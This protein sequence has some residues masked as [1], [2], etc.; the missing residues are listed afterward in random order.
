MKSTYLFLIIALFSLFPSAQAN[1]SAYYYFKQI[2]I[3]EGLPSSVTTVYDGNDG[4]L[5]IGTIYGAYR[6][7]G[8]KLKRY[9]PSAKGQNIPYIYR[10]DGDKQGNIWMFHPEGT[11]RYNPEKDIFEAFLFNNKPLEAH[12]LLSESNQLIFP[13]IGALLRYTKDL[14]YNGRIIVKEGEK[15]VLCRKIKIYNEKYYIASTQY[16]QLVLIDRHTG[17]VQES[18]FG[19]QTN[20]QDFYVDSKQ[21]FWI[22]YYGKGVSCYTQGGSLI[23]SFHTR[24]SSLSN[25][26]VLDIEERNGDIWLATDGGGINIIKGDTEEITVLSNNHDHKFPANSVTCLHNGVNNMWIGM[27][28]E[29]VLGAKENFITTYS[30]APQNDPSGLSEKC[31]LSLLEDKDGTIWIGT[32]GGGINSFNPK[33]EQFTHFPSTSG[34]KIVSI[35]PYSDSELL[36]SSFT[37]GIYLFDKKSGRYHRFQ[38]MGKVMDDEI[39]YS[40]SPTN[41][42]VNFENEIEFHGEYAYR[43]VRDKNLFTK[44]QV[45][46]RQYNESAIAIGNY[47]ADTY[48]H[49]KN[50]VFCYNRQSDRFES[51]YK[52]QGNQIL[53]AY[54]EPTGGRIWI[55]EKSGLSIYHIESGKTTP[56]KLPDQNDIVTSLIMDRKGVLWMGTSGALYAYFPKEQRFILFSESDGVLPNDFLPKPV[57]LTRNGDVYMG[58]AMGLARVNQS[59]NKQMHETS[60]A[61][62]ISLLDVNLNGNN[63]VPEQ[64]GQVSRLEIPSNFSSLRVHTKLDGTDIFRKR[65]YRY[66]I[67]GLNH[68]FTESS[69]SHF[70]IPTLPPGHYQIKAQCTQS[71]GLWS[72]PFTLLDLTVLPPWWQRTWFILCVVAALISAIIYIIRRREEHLQQKLKEKEREIYKEKVQALI[73]INHELRTPLTLIYTPL[74]Q[75]LSSRQVPLELRGKLQGAFKQARQMKNIINMILHM[76]KMEVGKN[77]L[78]LTPTLLN[79]WLQDIVNDFK[80]EFDMRNIRLVFDADSNI[81]TV[82]FDVGQCEIILNNLLMNAYKFSHPD[83]TVTVSTRLEQAGSII[84]IEVCDEGI[85]LGAVDPQGL[86]TRFEQGDH[87][88]QG[89]GIGLSYAKQLVEMHQGTIGAMNNKEKGATFYFTLPNRQEPVCVPCPAKPYL[90]EL[91]PP[92]TLSLQKAE[93]LPNRFHS[94][95]I[96][97]DDPDLCDYL[98]CNL[99][100]MFEVI[101]IAHDGM[102]AIPIVVSHLP[103]LIISDVIMPRMD[104]LELCRK[105]KQSAEF[106]YIPVILLASHADE[107]STE[108]GYKTGADAYVAK[109]FDMDTL[110]LQIQ[111]I[112]NH[113]SIVQKRYAGIEQ[114][115]KKEGKMNNQ[116]DEQFVVQLNNV[117]RE[118]RANVTLDVNLVA[119]LMRMSRASLYNK[120]KTTIGI[121]VNEYITKQRIEYAAQ[122]LMTTELSIRDI[123][124]QTGFSHQ[125][126]FS[127]TFKSLMGESPSEYR[128]RIVSGS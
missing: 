39:S 21:R 64:M 32:D 106:N 72:V 57:L 41:L 16:Q 86:F 56:I 34:G 63:V 74:K 40:G 80:D 124:E 33:T 97:D 4:F 116:A 115:E 95:L 76:R 27:V 117:I 99:Q 112:L 68:S 36:V 93:V 69:K 75:L 35:C 29:G 73:N 118:N 94:V 46:S 50:I 108:D 17:E 100:A 44:I 84:R 90:N 87:H 52:K 53:T 107:P 2:S 13:V 81:Q 37:K 43:Y 22:A 11:S 110:L 48:Y 25:D 92:Q 79:E 26:V 45:P 65:I 127:T 23:R 111:N 19:K 119:E 82:S 101:H 114:V 15:E 54:L 104:G 125:R 8:E 120:M 98:A 89:S 49:N 103:Q 60:T 67:E 30:K 1:G 47:Q 5:W 102:E 9:S 128:K 78:N 12:T 6:F 91:L 85:G 58:G 96:V 71:D 123:S 77:T 28:R 113:Q 38:G 55:A 31:P 105:V 42:F 3:K 61:L 109:P 66:Q 24:N 88:I 62:R 7:D 83:T 122:L 10:I 20:V 14:R 126:N 121:G 18:P 51:V 70:L 59:M